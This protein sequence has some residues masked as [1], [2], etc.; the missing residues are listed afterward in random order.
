[1]LPPRRNRNSDKA[2][3]GKRCLE[4][5]IALVRRDAEHNSDWSDRK[6]CNR[7]CSISH[8]NRLY[9]STHEMLLNNSEGGQGCW[10]WT[11]HVDPKG[12]GRCAKVMGEVLT[13]RIAYQEFI[14]PIPNG[15]HVLHSCDNPPC[16]NPA[17]LRVGTNND[18][19]RDRSERD[20]CSAMKGRANPNW[21]H[22][23]Y[24]K[25]EYVT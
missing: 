12:Y 23:R 22:G 9:S 2:D 24:T 14:G 11:G 17:H 8:K 15:L 7:S 18:N 1:M 21:K 13:H 3:C 25:E 6:F 16:I 19:M 5:D 20:R 10:E 4:C